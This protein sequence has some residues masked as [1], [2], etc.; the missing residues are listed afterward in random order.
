MKKHA[1]RSSSKGNRRVQPTN[2][3]GIHGFMPPPAGFDP[4]SATPE[5]L[6]A[7]GFPPRPDPNSM[8]HAFKKWNL[9][10]SRIRRF[11][12]PELVI[13]P[14]KTKL[15]A[16]SGTDNLQKST[17]WSGWAI[18]ASQPQES[19][20]SVQ[21]MWNIP[22]VRVPAPPFANSDPVDGVWSSAI[23][24]G[25][26][27][28][29]GNE[30]LQAGT[31]QEIIVANGVSTLRYYAWYEWF[32]NALYE[33]SNFPVSPGQSVYAFVSYGGS[34]QG[35]ISMVNLSTGTMTGVLVDPPASAGKQRGTDVEWVLEAP[36]FGDAI[37][38]LADYGTV[39]MTDLVASESGGK[40]VSPAQFSSSAIGNDIVLVE[41][42]DSKTVS[43]ASLG[44]A[45]SFFFSFP[46]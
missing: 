11:I 15:K 31:V 27:G 8:P 44:P 30:V 40:L 32:P 37:G 26:D 41:G 13:S 42:P 25:M 10:A 24:V 39:I 2:I 34:S 18:T 23:W 19:F 16:A 45:L 17:A 14:S 12:V 3:P 36:T 9:M 20:Q 33:F 5:E 46:Q 22:L 35:S 4:R 1:N 6:H 28:Y 29:R 21:A 38:S 7:H 43:G